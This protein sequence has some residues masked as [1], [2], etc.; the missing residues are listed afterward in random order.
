[1]CSCPTCHVAANNVPVPQSDDGAATRHF[2]DRPADPC[3]EQDNQPLAKL[4]KSEA[5]RLFV[6]RAGAVRPDFVLTGANAAAVGEICRRLDGIPL[7][8]EL[9]A[10]RV[11]MLTPEQIS[12]QEFDELVSDLDAGPL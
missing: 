7:A 5:V 6:E 9:A 3:P 11:A 4:A 12:R 8:I 1:V 10:A 2:D